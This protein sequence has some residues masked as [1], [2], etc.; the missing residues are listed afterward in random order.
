MERQDASRLWPVPGKPGPE[1]DRHI[2]WKELRTLRLSLTALLPEV[3]GQHVLLWEDNMP[4]VHIVMNGTSRSPALMSE[5]RHLWAFLLQHN[6]TLV[7]R[8]IRSSDNPAHRWSRWKDRSAWQLQPGVA[9][10]LQA[11]F[12]HCTLDAFACR[13]TVLLPRYCSAGPDPGCL[14]RDAFTM[15]WTHERSK[16]GSTHHGNCCSVLFTTGHER[17]SERHSGGLSVRDGHH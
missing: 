17:L 3:Q 6:I 13:A 5:L 2:T 10:H 8:Y 16:C 15:L 14:Q 9:S 12:G 4:V 7:P 11:L 1:R